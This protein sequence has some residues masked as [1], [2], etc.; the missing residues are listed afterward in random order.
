MKAEFRYFLKQFNIND[1]GRLKGKCEEKMLT[2][3][4][5]C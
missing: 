1:N 2:L 4:N 5:G 3:H